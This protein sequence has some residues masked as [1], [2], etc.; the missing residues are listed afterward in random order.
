MT[1]ALVTGADGFIGSHLVQRLVAEGDAVRA[2]CVYNSMGSVG[3]L[4]DL[5]PEELAKV[6]V[7]FADVRDAE[8]VRALVDGVDVV[9]HLA[10]LIAIPYSYASPRSFVETNVVGTLNVLEAARTVGTGRVVHTSTSEVYGTPE[11][12]PIDERHPLHGQSPYSASKIGADMLAEAW[13]RSFEVPVTVLRPFNTFGP[14]QSARAVIPTVLGQ[15]LAGAEEIRLGALDPRRDFTYV[16]DTVDGFVRAAR[17][18][19]GLPGEVIQ[20][21]TGRDVSIGELVELCRSVTGSA[22]R[23]VQ[24]SERVRP[25]N[26]EVERLLSAPARALERLGW[27]PQVSLEDGLARTAEWLRRTDL[28][29]AAAYQL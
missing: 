7:Q 27:A 24:E 4:A 12:V 28:R 23:I 3:W 17:A 8:R 15:M 20:L 18:P 10:A 26:S 11:T 13:A 6:D 29:T 1:T 5:S 19:L 22:A 14:R 9:Y 16:T 2:M 25:A 21:G